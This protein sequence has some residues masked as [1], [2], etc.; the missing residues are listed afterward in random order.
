MSAVEKFNRYSGRG[1]EE[2]RKRE[3]QRSIWN[4]MWFITINVPPRKRKCGKVFRKRLKKK[5][6]KKSF[7]L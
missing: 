5:T 2:E 4:T 7:F 6:F 3:R 1:T